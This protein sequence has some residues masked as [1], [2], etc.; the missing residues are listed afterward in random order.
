MKRVVLGLSLKSKFVIFLL[1]LL[2]LLTFSSLVSAQ[3]DT[4]T[5]VPPAEFS[6]VATNFPLTGAHLMLECSACHVSGLFKGTPRTCS[7]CHAKG[8]LIVAT[9]KPVNHVTTNDPCDVCHT[10]TV[11]F[12]GAR[13]NHSNMA[14]GSCVSCHNGQVARGKPSNHNAVL[15][16][17]ET[18][19][20]CHRTYVWIPATFNH[21]GVVPGTC[22]T[23]CHNGLLATGRPS[24]HTSVLKATST[25]DTCHRFSAWHPSFYNHVS[26]VPSSCVTCHN[27]ASATGKPSSHA[28]SK[29]SLACDKCHSSS[30]WLPASYIHAGVIPGSC[31]TCHGA[32]RPSSHFSRGYTGSCDLCHSVGSTWAFNHALQQGQHTCNGCHSHHNNATPCDYCHSVN[33]W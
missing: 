14:P 5:Q 9:V 33:R 2:S 18:C 22:A 6:H 13:F 24:S 17:A 11:S 20:R 19:D 4:T 29:A 12:F 28:G 1:A 23:Q 25:C 16:L 27:G 8:K 10:N 26:V 32:Q 31:V 30:A 15:Q 3:L 21:T 7:E